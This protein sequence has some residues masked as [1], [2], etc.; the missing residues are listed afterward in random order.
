MFFE[1][2]NVLCILKGKMPFKMHKIILF[3]KKEIIK[4]NMCAYVF[5]KFSDLL[6]KTRIFFY[7]V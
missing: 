3:Q 6:P 4:K 7:S 5:L 2:K 1:Q